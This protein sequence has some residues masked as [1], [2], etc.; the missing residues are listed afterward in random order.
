MGEMGRPKKVVA[1]EEAAEPTQQQP[2]EAGDAEEETVQGRGRTKKK[3][4]S[5]GEEEMPAKK[6]GPAA[7]APA[8]AKLRGCPPGGW[9]EKPKKGPYVPT[10]KPRG[11][12]PGGWPKKVDGRGAHLRKDPAVKKSDDD[13]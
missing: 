3:A 7:T 8:G 1:N 2:L 4:D 10:G 11:C 9:P 6:K 5:D 13:E 12:P